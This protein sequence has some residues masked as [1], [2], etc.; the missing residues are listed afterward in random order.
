[1]QNELLDIM[2][3]QVLSKRLEAIRKGFYNIMCDE[4]TDCSNFEHLSFNT[5]IVDDELEVHE[6]FL[7]F[8]EIE[9][10]KSDTIVS[11][12]KDVLLRLI[13]HLTFAVAKFMT[14]QAI[15]SVKKVVLQHKFLKFNQRLFSRTVMATL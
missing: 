3:K 15:W 1:M 14:E 9:N 11:A 4:G 13:C 8:Y 6:D 7:G 2:A 5:R 12:I 10:I